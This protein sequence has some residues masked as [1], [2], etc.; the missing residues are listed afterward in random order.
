MTF[1]LT[2]NFTEALQLAHKWHLGQYRKGTQTP[3]LSHLLGVASVALEF[4]ATEAEAIAALLHD[5]LEDGPENLTA[6]KNEREQVRGEL[7]AQI[8]A[9]FGDEVAA[10]VRGA[11]EETPLVDG[12]KAPWPKRKLTYL[13]KLNR[14]GASSL[15]VSA[16]DKLHN[17]RSILTDVLTEG[18]TPEAREAYFGRFSQ[19][20]EGTLQYYRLLADAYKQ[21][22]GAAGR[23]RLQALFAELERT[24]SALEVA[25]GV[26][27]DEVRR[28]VPLRSAHPDEALGLI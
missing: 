15:L 22:P 17:A 10:L 27:P 1:P 7:E 26:T 8:Q 6:D 19:G 5:A 28:Y 13:G 21:A 9:K 18:T 25:C 24:V 11:T 4:G 14:E 23:P 3:Y 16:S 12:G 20:R 2:E